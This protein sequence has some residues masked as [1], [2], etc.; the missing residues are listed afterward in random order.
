MTASSTG[1]TGS[2]VP[3]PIPLRVQGIR[4]VRAFLARSPEGGAL[5]GFLAVFLF[6][7]VTAPLFLTSDSIS[8]I[9]TTQSI[10]GIVA[11][12]VAFLM[13]T[14]EFDLSVGSVLAV[15]GL[16]F[17]ALAMHN[18]PIVLSAILAVLAGS[19]MGLINGL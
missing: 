12:G 19:L 2:T 18:V 10:S 6:F 13:M 17:L 8:S 7:S 11:V 15:S 3:E 9:A 16:T 14:G 4:L 1:S 5:I